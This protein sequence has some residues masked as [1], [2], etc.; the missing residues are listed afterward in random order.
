MSTSSSAEAEEAAQ[1][2]AL[3]SYKD[4]LA[5][6]DMTLGLLQTEEEKAPLMQL[7]EDLKELIQI[8]EEGLLQ[9]KKDNLMKLISG[10]TGSS[11]GVSKESSLVNESRNDI[12][13]HSFDRSVTT[14]DPA[15]SSSSRNFQTSSA[16]P[17]PPPLPPSNADELFAKYSPLLGTSCRAPFPPSRRS[18]V[19]NAIVHSLEG[20]DDEGELQVK[21]IYTHPQEPKMV[22]CPFFLDD[23]CRFE[24]GCRQNHGE[25]VNASELQDYIE[26]DFET[27]VSIGSLCL[28]K[29]DAASGSGQRTFPLWLPG[30]VLHLE[31]GLVTVQIKSVNQT[32]AVPFDEIFPLEDDDDDD[33][34]DIDDDDEDSE[35]DAPSS[36]NVNKEDEEEDVVREIKVVSDLSE[37]GRWE[38]STR[39][40]AS[41]L[42]AKWGYVKGN[43]LGKDGE[44][45]VV[46][47]EARIFPQGKSL[48]VCMAMRMK[49]EGLSA[50][51]TLLKKKRERRKR[52]KGEDSAKKGYTRKTK[53]EESMSA[54]N[55]IN[56]IKLTKKGGTI[57]VDEDEAVGT[58]K[59][60]G[61]NDQK[62]KSHDSSKGKSCKD[63]RVQALQTEGEMAKVEKE[64]E[65]VDE[66]IERNEKKNPPVAAQ[67]REKKKE[68]EKYKIKLK[69]SLRSI[70]GEQRNRNSKQKMTIF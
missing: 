34:S 36:T 7:V 59:S 60:T 67:A 8:S 33:D 31:E 27:G 16:S 52:K 46:P 45:R 54:F 1:E 41:K 38:E 61:V 69:S 2:A 47:V 50:D 56:S 6:V 51:E 37:F 49:R 43:G 42:L 12:V 3:Q 40:I 44:G 5:Q 14:S 58:D 66:T 20:I 9:L 65:K 53:E 70:Q 55:F 62:H 35:A 17:S 18:G 63:L 10:D 39:G 48:D 25:I 68:L 57:T 30:E 28:V 29:H 15:S 11:A 26:P 64:I 13:H 21:V 32:V 4:Q 23:R 19:H 22:T 24:E